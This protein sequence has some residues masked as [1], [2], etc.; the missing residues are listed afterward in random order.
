MLGY[1]IKFDLMFYM[2]ICDIH[3]CSGDTEPL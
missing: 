1:T 2:E 3:I